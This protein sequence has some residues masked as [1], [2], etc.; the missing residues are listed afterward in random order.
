[1]R[2]IIVTTPRSGSTLITDLLGNLAKQHSGYKNTLQEYFT[3][4]ELYNPEY[5]RINDIV[6]CTKLDRKLEFWYDNKRDEILKRLALVNNDHNYMIKLFSEDIEPEV[7]TMIDDNYDIIYLERRDKLSQYISYMNM[8]GTNIA[9]HTVD[10]KSIG[11]IIY[12]TK[13]RDEFIRINDNYFK[14]KKNHPS[15][16]PT[17]Y[18]EDFIE[19]GSDEDSLI[20]L[21]NLDIK[22]YNKL[23]V[24]TIPTPYESELESLILNKQEWLLDREY[25]VNEL[26]KNM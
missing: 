5:S 23:S 4:T 20:R 21:L 10:S 12:W 8:I 6:Y 15:K 13:F 16:Y 18:Y 3:I 1:M 2:P 11:K 9:H 22:V 7:Q 19:Q 14:Y 24:K 26:Y 25:I 17:I